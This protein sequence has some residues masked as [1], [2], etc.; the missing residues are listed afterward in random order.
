MSPKESE[1]SGAMSPKG[2]DFIQ[3][4]KVNQFD[5]QLLQTP[6]NLKES[7]LIC[8]LLKTIL[9]GHRYA[10]ILKSVSPEGNP[11]KQKS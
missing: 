3:P 6:D 4:F 8:V 10:Q 5:G 7:D 11:F 1:L 2:F 9:A